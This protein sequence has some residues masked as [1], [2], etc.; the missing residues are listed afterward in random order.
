MPRVVRLLAICLLLLVAT[1]CSRTLDTNSLENSL[2][3]QMESKTGVSGFT[4]TCPENIKAVEGG[5]FTCT[6]AAQGET[7][8]LQVTQ[9]DAQGHVT[10]RA[11]P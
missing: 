6:A 9:T 3:T 11:T 2:K 1:S 7:V 5:T 4:I 8:T 10:F